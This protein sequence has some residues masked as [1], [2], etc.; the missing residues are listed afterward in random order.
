M[1]NHNQL[2]QAGE[3][4]AHDFL[5]SRGWII[6]E[7]NWRMGKLELDLV[8]EDPQNR[9]LHI[10]EVKT[11]TSIEHYDPMQAISLKKQRNL[12][13]AANGYVGFY[14][15]QMSVA[16]DVVIVEGDMDAGFK[17]HYIPNAFYPRVRTFR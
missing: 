17:I 5:L 11:R 14:K 7:R 4:A 3:K 9:V 6:R 2:G 10:V 13:N 16:F 12:I 1:D 15:L 8:V